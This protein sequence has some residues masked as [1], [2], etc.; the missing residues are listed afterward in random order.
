MLV[1]KRSGEIKVEGFRQ[2]LE[3]NIKKTLAFLSFTGHCHVMCLGV[4]DW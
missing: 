2:R 4:N 1:W 3:V